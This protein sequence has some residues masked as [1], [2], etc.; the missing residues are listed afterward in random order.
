[1]KH[2]FRAVAPV[3]LFLLLVGSAPLSL[4][5]A[6][7]LP[8]T[9]KDV[10]GNPD[11]SSGRG[12]ALK[13]LPDGK[14]YSRTRIDSVSKKPA[15]FLTD[16]RT[17]K[18]EIF[19]TTADLKIP[20]TERTLSFVDYTWSKDGTKILFVRSR[21]AI[22]RR[23]T[24]DQVIV[25]DHGKKALIAMP[26]H[27]EGVRHAKLSPDGQWVGYVCKEDLY[28]VNLATGAES[29]L[30]EDGGAH[31][32][33]GRFG[34]VYEEEFSITDGWMWSPDSKRIAYWQEDERR[35][36]EYSMM[37]WMPLHGELIPIRYPKA[38][39]PNPVMRV[40]VVSLESRR[41]T[42][43][44][45]GAGTAPLPVPEPGEAPGIVTAAH[46]VY[47][48]RMAWT[49]DKYTLSFMKMNR[50]QNRLQ[51]WFADAIT[52]V[53]RVVVDD[54]STTGWIDVEQ[55]VTFLPGR[56]EFVWQS[57]RDGWNHLYL[58][59]YDGKLLRQLTKG[60]WEVTDLVGTDDDGDYLYFVST[61]VSP[62]ERHL[63]RIERDGS[64]KE[65]LTK[66]SGFHRISAS[67]T[68]AF[69][70]DSW[71]SLSQPAMTR[72]CNEDGE[73][74]RVLSR[75]NPAAFDKYQWMPREI[76]RF[77][78][79]DGLELYCSMIKPPDFDPSKRYPVFVDVYGGPGYQ[80]VTNSWPSPM[81]QWVA[82]QGFITVQIDNRGGGARGAD[83][84]HRVYKQLGKWEANDFVEGAK[85]L[86]TLPYVDKDRIGIWGWSYGG[87]MSALT[88]MLGTGTYAAAV[89]IAPV[90]DWKFYDTIYAERYMQR[91]QDNPAGY[92]VGSCLEHA[93]KL[94]GHLL[95]IHG[96]LDDNVHLQNTMQLV[97]R[98]ENAGIQFDMRIYPNGDHGVASGM[99]SMYGLYEYFMT[100]MKNKLSVH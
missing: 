37:D 60:N 65:Q 34:W 29:R 89:S 97:D 20:G 76:T 59:S 98:L 7:K 46:D 82:N 70:S 38:G 43:I 31:V 1:M 33:N 3:L 16:A 15:I 14:R 79:A 86:A 92:K 21:K 100:F 62:L 27:P 75:V 99:D 36:P 40:G 53:A 42:W 9:V 88:M 68:C 30:T 66:A 17:G 84:K 85:F 28:V 55:N 41:T 11:F 69:F 50:H 52:G 26:D 18:E 78:T 25:Y 6:Q 45:Y 57:E 13:W 56:K 49:D 5:F 12:G 74:M 73:E 2:L 91:P 48:P 39:D 35:V 63:Y 94:K 32:F 87:Y 22:W 72:L 8:I 23:S 58:Y 10:F 80:N 44:D 67:P 4:L 19:L 61:E 90:T 47:I 81:H 83:F 71:S 54:S 95:V 77:K 51:L 93:T 96:G 24:V 64:D